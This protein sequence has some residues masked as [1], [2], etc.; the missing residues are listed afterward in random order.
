MPCEQLLDRAASSPYWAPQGPAAQAGCSQPTDTAAAAAQ[1]RGTE[2]LGMLGIR[3]KS[4]SPFEEG[5]SCYYAQSTLYRPFAKNGSMYDPMRKEKTLS[6]TISSCCP[7]VIIITPGQLL[8]QQLHQAPGQQ[9]H[10]IFI[11]RQPTNL[12]GGKLVDPENL[13]PTLL[14]GIEI[15]ALV[16]AK[17]HRSRVVIQA[18]VIQHVSPLALVPGKSCLMCKGSTSFCL[19]DGVLFGI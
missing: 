4:F 12:Q 11:Y 8:G 9:V 5:V 13:D 7:G 1:P 17:T 6:A 3:S 14:S 19:V 2:E 10:L 18:S 16:I 15:E